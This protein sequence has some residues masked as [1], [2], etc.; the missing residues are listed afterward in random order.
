MAEEKAV[1]APQ[2]DQV[3][4]QITMQ[5]MCTKGTYSE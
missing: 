5:R 2:E 4:Q 3:Q 1:G